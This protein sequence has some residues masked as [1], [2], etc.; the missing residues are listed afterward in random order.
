ME[1][2]SV[3]RLC[4]T[5]NIALHVAFFFLGQ[6]DGTE[7]PNR[8]PTGS[9]DLAQVVRCCRMAA[10]TGWSR[11][12]QLEERLLEMSLYPMDWRI[13]RRLV[14]ALATLGWPSVYSVGP[15]LYGWPINVTK[16]RPVLDSAITLQVLGKKPQRS[17]NTQLGSLVLHIEYEKHE[18]K[19]TRRN[20][21]LFPFSK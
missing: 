11:G 18:I 6:N 19:R 10:I 8:I 17:R 16:W 13:S 2:R 20:A 9:E 1:T 3:S 14:L 5:E 21:F 4:P 12:G 7:V 15:A